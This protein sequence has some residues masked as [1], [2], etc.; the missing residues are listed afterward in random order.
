MQPATRTERILARHAMGSESPARP[1]PV[2]GAVPSGEPMENRRQCI[3]RFVQAHYECPV[4]QHLP[5]RCYLHP[6]WEQLRPRK[7]T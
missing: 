5:S 6:V 2:V 1:S 4:A 7:E 3:E